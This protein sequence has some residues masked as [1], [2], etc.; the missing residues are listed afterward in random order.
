MHVSNSVSFFTF[1]AIQFVYSMAPFD[2][3]WY[4]AQTNTILTA[5]NEYTFWNLTTAH[6][7]DIN[8]VT[9]F[10]K[11]STSSTGDT[12]KIELTWMSDGENDCPSEMWTSSKYAYQCENTSKSYIEDCA[13]HSV[14]CL[15]GT[16]DFRVSL[17]ESEGVFINKS[18]YSN[19]VFDTMKGYEFRIFPHVST[20][21]KEYHDDRS[22]SGHGAMVPCA[23]YFKTS[24]DPFGSGRIG[25]PQGCFNI[26]LGKPYKMKFEIKR[27]SS[28]EMKLTMSIGNWSLSYDHK[29]SSS[30]TKYIPGYIDTMAI[31][32]ANERMYYYIGM[33][34]S[35]LTDSSHVY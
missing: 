3:T 31:D 10:S 21:A 23:F 34:Y 9:Q 24:N 11:Q 12:A 30:D 17:L 1:Y 8:I 33:G 13:H 2:S 5:T 7:S 25:T 6:G 32:Y 19:S 18:G 15:A 28:Y 20:K 35:N 16:G 4:T 14:N 26:A 22:G 29:W 27:E